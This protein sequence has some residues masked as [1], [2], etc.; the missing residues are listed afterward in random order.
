VTTLVDISRQLSNLREEVQRL[1]QTQNPLG[2]L[3]P[4]V[5]NPTSLSR[6]WRGRTQTEESLLKSGRF[7]PSAADR[8]LPYE[9]EDVHRHC[10]PRRVK[11]VVMNGQ[12]LAAAIPG[13]AH[14]WG[15]LRLATDEMFEAW[16]PL[17][18]SNGNSLTRTITV[19]T[20]ELGYVTITKSFD[21]FG[22]SFL[23]VYRF[24]I[25]TSSKEAE[26]GEVIRIIEPTSGH[27]LKL[28]LPSSI[29]DI[30]DDDKSVAYVTAAVQ[31]GIRDESALMR[32]SQCSSRRPPMTSRSILDALRS[33]APAAPETFQDACLLAELQAR[34]LLN[35]W[36]ISGPPVPDAAVAGLSE[37]RA[38][39]DASHTATV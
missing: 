4:A 23:G 39:A 5:S 19:S 28:F 35:V 31:E 9:C 10:R 37:I 27:F 14:A 13:H 22:E 15:S 1:E 32:G 16:R 24:L 3:L 12:Y 17:W 18:Q 2:G 30:E 25:E 6:S 33:L 7:T 38:S 21:D 36:G 34:C 8:G 29:L 11:I 26:E 20:Q